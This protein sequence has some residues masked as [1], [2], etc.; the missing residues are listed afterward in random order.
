MELSWGFSLVFRNEYCYDVKKLYQLFD[1]VYN[2]LILKGGFLLKEVTEN[3]NIQAK[4][5]VHAFRDQEK[6]IKNIENI[7][8][9]NIKVSLGMTFA[10]SVLL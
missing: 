10:L 5:L 6:K 2:N 1:T 8:L 4:F 7:I 3:P 9:K